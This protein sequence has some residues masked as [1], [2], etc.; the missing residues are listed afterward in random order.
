MLNTSSEERNFALIDTLCERDLRIK[1]LTHSFA[2][3]ETALVAA[4]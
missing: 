1:M 3:A 4:D 2:A